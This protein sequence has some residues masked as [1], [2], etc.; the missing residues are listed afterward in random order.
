VRKGT[1]GM[2]DC[3]KSKCA[4]ITMLYPGIGCSIEVDGLNLMNERDSSAARLLLSKPTFVSL[5]T[6]WMLMDFIAAYG[7]VTVSEIPFV[8]EIITDFQFDER[9]ATMPQRGIAEEIVSLK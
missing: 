5:R 9:Y 1:Y 4:W 8:T 7:L 2:P 6:T 3:I